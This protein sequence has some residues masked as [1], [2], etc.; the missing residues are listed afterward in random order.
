MEWVKKCS[1]LNYWILLVGKN[2]DYISVCVCVKQSHKKHNIVWE[3]K[4]LDTNIN[5]TY[6]DFKICTI[7]Y[8]KAYI[9]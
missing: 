2:K 8:L 9:K 3:M 1:K 6:V 5:S 4:Y 7:V